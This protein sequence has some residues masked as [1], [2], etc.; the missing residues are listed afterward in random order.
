ML[1][2]YIFLK[3]AWT[4]KHTYVSVNQYSIKLNSSSATTGKTGS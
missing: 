2:T 4:Y 1:I 3:N